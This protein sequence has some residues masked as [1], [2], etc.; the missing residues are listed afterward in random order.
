VCR[1]LDVL[2][3][4][5]SAEQKQ[6]AERALV[7]HACQQDAAFV[8]VVGR[9]IADVLNPDGRFDDRD[10]ANRRGLTMGDQRPDG[11]SRLSGWL[12]PEA[13][14]YVEA[15][16]AAVRPG[17][18]LSGGDGV[19]D[20]ATDTRTGPQRLHDAVALGLRAGIESGSLGTHRGIPVT[21]IVTTTVADMEQAAR[22]AV[23]PAVP[24]PAP[25]RTGG[26]SALS[27]RELIRMA[28]GS[29]Q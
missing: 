17:H 24:M 16:G 26:G 23:D 20:G 10:R 22:A 11:M 3:N 14:A 18:R 5:V 2:P 25:A 4:V 21:V 7:R 15:L 12:T 27:M 8:A 1:A 28:A 19:V 13:R 6:K 9:R 29:V